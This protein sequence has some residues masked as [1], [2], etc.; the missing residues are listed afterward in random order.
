MGRKELPTSADDAQQQP[1]TAAH[2]HEVGCPLETLL[3]TAD[4]V[5]LN[6]SLELDI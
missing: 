3:S 5:G 2:S 1:S 4:S 6:D